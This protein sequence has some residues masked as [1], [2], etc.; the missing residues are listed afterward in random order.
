TLQAHGLLPN[1]QQ[2]IHTGRNICVR[3]C[4]LPMECM[5]SYN[6]P[7]AFFWK[8][9]LV[10]A[11]VAW[12]C[13][14][15]LTKRLQGMLPFLHF[16]LLFNSAP[17]KRSLCKCWEN[18]GWKVFASTGKHFMLMSSASFCRYPRILLNAKV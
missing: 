10:R 12:L 14:R 5:K 3:L 16:A 1:R 15:L 13:N 6:K 17:I 9:V 8:W 18:L 11:L 7:K 4:C 2:T